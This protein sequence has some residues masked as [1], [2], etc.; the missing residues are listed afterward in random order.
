MSGVQG[1]EKDRDI[2]NGVTQTQ[3][4]AADV[5]TGGGQV[6]WHQG[7]RAVP[8]VGV[9]GPEPHGPCGHSTAVPWAKAVLPGS[10]EG[11]STPLHTPH[12][13]HAPSASWA[14]ERPREP[15][16]PGLGVPCDAPL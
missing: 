7:P 9:Q 10:E 15:G 4:C 6:A 3:G 1:V 5:Q 13:T 12:G 2:V 8:A 14:A 16:P 11:T